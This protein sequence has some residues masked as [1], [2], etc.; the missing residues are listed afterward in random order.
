MSAELNTWLPELKTKQGINLLS[1]QNSTGV[2]STHEAQA[3][4]MS[5][6]RQY[7]SHLKPN[8]AIAMVDD[9]TKYP[10]KQIPE[11]VSVQLY[12]LHE[13]THVCYSE[14][15]ESVVCSQPTWDIE[16][17]HSDALWS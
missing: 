17:V 1:G 16:G 11:M 9:F 6:P 5:G 3:E 12:S 7:I 8:L 13:S 10:A 4:I 14:G 15:F 2:Q